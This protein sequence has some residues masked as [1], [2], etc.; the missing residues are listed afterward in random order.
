MVNK[1]L[2]FTAVWVY[3]CVGDSDLDLKAALCH[4]SE[5]NELT[6]CFLAESLMKI[7]LW[8]NCW[9]LSLA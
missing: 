5:R 9:Q 6:F 3:I 1:G 8:T 2:R 4:F 7:L